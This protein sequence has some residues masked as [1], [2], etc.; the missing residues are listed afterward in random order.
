M[1]KPIRLAIF[2]N[3]I[4]IVKK[5]YMK[6]LIQV[7]LQVFIFSLP[8]SIYADCTIDN[9]K[10]P[11]GTTLLG[12]SLAGQQFIACETG[13]ITSIQVKTSGG[14]VE[15]YLIEGDGEDIVYGV[16]Y[17]K[18]SNQAS[19]LITLDLTVP[20]PISIDSLYAFAVGGVDSVTFDMQPVGFPARPDL[21][22][23]QFSFEITDQNDFDEIV[24][25]DLVFG[26]TS[27]SLP[28][29]PRVVSLVPTLSTW[30]LLIFGLLLL[31][32]SLIL[33]QNAIPKPP[34]N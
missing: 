17:Q 31:N 8:V 30:S 9:T 34:E 23:G 4:I 32:L 19:G 25:S 1:I 27:I 24:P 10:N 33:I 7:I 2:L 26:I 15:L 3:T 22:N 28:P 20:F 16:P 14:N 6:I 18:F 5:S 21:P 13:T 29:P 12:S 11:S